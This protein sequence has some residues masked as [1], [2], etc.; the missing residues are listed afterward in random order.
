[1]THGEYMVGLEFNPGN[2]SKVTQIKRLAADLID[3]I[4]TIEVGDI[5]EKGRL[6]SLA[7]TS[8]ETGAMWAVKAETKPAK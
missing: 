1:M 4:S 2:H 8:I 6:K 5:P 3:M 7:M